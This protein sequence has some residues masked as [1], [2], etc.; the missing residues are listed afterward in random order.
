MKNKKDCLAAVFFSCFFCPFV[1]PLLVPLF[2]LG[3]QR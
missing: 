3:T 1:Y 2:V